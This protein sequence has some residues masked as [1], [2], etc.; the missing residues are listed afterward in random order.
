MKIGILALAALG[1][2]M[3]NAS[4]AA[5][6]VG[7]WPFDRT[8]DIRA[9]TDGQFL[10]DAEP[11]MEP[12][13]AGLFESTVNEAAGMAFDYR[14]PVTAL[15]AKGAAAVYT[16]YRAES[17]KGGDGWALNTS[18]GGVV[19]A[20]GPRLLKTARDF[21]VWVKFQPLNPD[22][23]GTEIIL[24][25]PGAWLLCRSQ[26]RL[27]AC[28]N[29]RIPDASI[30]GLNGDVFGG[31]GPLL[32]TGQWHDVGFSFSGDQRVIDQPKKILI[33]LDGTLI[34]TAEERTAVKNTEPLQFGGRGLDPAVCFPDSKF[35]LDRVI[36]FDG[37]VAI[38]DFAD[39]ARNG[40]PEIELPVVPVIPP[41]PV[42]SWNAAGPVGPAANCRPLLYYPKTDRYVT[43]P[44]AEA[45][46]EI[47]GDLYFQPVYRPFTPVAPEFLGYLGPGCRGNAGRPDRYLVALYIVPTSTV[48]TTKWT[49]SGAVAVRNDE[50]PGAKLELRFYVNDSLKTTRPV[51]AGTE[52]TM[53]AVD[54][55]KLKAGDKIQV[56]FGVAS[57]GERNGLTFACTLDVSPAKAPI[58]LPATLPWNQAFRVDPAKP[59]PPAAGWQAA[60]NQVIAE[61]RRKPMDLLFIGESITGFWKTSGKAVWDTRLLRYKPG[62][63]GISGQG[64][65]DVLWRFEHGAFDWIHPKAVVVMLGGHNLNWTAAELAAGMAAVVREIREHHPACTIIV[66]G[67]LPRQ[68]KPNH[69]E[70]A[71]ILEVNALMKKLDDGKTVRFV[72]FGAKLLEPDGTLSRETAPDFIHPGPRAYELWADAIQPILDPLFP[73]P[74]ARK[75]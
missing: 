14:H 50:S 36:F 1:G 6:V 10:P 73:P 61:L 69:P 40:G 2:F 35:L 52:A 11:A 3:A 58:L 18:C 27:A 53:F 33:F 5:M 63:A 22:P 75:K 45:A 67:I 70:R 8:V 62:N 9:V 15:P 72:D 65:Q 59:S 57:L 19:L 30:I 68:E 48:R 37:L 12:S 23:A 46:A 51:T 49:A 4:R 39:L 74:P 44:D 32:P 38:S 16:Q 60:H 42:L 28:F 56:A 29:G 47:G 17:V 71:K 54:L 21:S 26:G 25:R 43:R 31:N 24:G 55:G 41:P 64:T 34:K 7:D 66:M 20:D 13:S